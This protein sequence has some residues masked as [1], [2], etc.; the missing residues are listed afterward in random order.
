MIHGTILGSMSNPCM[1]GV[2][3]TKSCNLPA[4]RG[5]QLARNQ[6]DL[7]QSALSRAESLWS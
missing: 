6:D 5:G 1:L 4:G 2:S 7:Y 3:C